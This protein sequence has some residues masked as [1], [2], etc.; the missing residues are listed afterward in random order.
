LN[1]KNEWASWYVGESPRLEYFLDNKKHESPF[2]I[3][4]KEF[5]VFEQKILKILNG[6]ILQSKYH[7]MHIEKK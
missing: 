1:D 3:D 6:A 5:N 7:R 4:R 2:K